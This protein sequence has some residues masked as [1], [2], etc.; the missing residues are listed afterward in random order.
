MAVNTKGVTRRPAPIPLRASGVCCS[1]VDVRA[2]DAEQAGALAGVFA[3]LADPARLRIYSIITSAGEACSCDLEGPT[4][5][6]QPTVSH[7]TARL[8]EAGLIEGE[9]RGRWTWWRAVPD[10]VDAVSRILGR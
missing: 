2:L 8:V 3:A 10:Q 6:S 7:H 5:L 4:G 1:P 9:R